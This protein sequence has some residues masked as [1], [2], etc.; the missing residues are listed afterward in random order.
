MRCH[1]CGSD[2]HLMRNCPKPLHHVQ[3]SLP[4]VAAAP[5]DQTLVP[6]T[7]HMQQHFYH[8]IEAAADAP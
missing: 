5:S 2:E 3:P 1:E 7:M 4:A 6:G 8:R